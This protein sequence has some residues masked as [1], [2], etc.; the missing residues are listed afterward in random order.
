MVFKRKIFFSAVVLAAG[1]S[2]RFGGQKLLMPMGESTIVENTIDNI[3]KSRVDHLIVVTGYEAKRFNMLKKK[4][5]VQLVYNKEH[6]S[7]MSSSI[8]CGVRSISKKSGAVII[9]LADQPFI[10]TDIIDIL[11]ESYTCSEKGI[12][13]PVINKQRGHPVI[14]SMKYK[15]DLMGL[16]GDRGARDI[17]NNNPDDIEEI[18]VNTDNILKD[19]DTPFDYNDLIKN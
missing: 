13:Y 2:R 7:G 9:L 6:A 14:F 11:L 3:C 4:N 15:N 1:K 16:K 10:N 17:I 19:I 12:L 5:K 18:N 8:V